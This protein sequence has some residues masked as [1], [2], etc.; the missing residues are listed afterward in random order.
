MNP[1]SGMSRAKQRKRGTLYAEGGAETT[2]NVRHVGTLRSRDLRVV[3]FTYQGV[4]GNYFH[5]F[6]CFHCFDRI[7]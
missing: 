2:V 6:H 1:V 5:C 3:L 4:A 7:Y